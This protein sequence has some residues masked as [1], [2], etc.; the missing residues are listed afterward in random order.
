MDHTGGGGV[1]VVIVGTGV[2]G[3]ELSLNVVHVALCAGNALGDGLHGGV[4]Q[5]FY[6]ALALLHHGLDLSI[7]VTGS[8]I[9]RGI[10]GLLG[11]LALVGLVLIVV[12]LIFGVC[13]AEVVGIILHALQQ[14]VVLVQ[15][16]LVD[17]ELA[18]QVILLHV[19]IRALDVGHEVA[20][21]HIAALRN[22]HLGNGAGITGHDI[23]FIAGLHGACVLADINAVGMG[24]PH[25]QKQHEDAHQ[26]DKSVAIRR[27]LFFHHDAAVLQIRKVL[28]F[29]RHN[30]LVSIKTSTTASSSS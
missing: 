18:F 19:D 28:N 23:G 10:K 5:S 9:G 13:L 21:V 16:G 20:L 6:F 30:Y 4:V 1:D 29:N 12:G 25:H 3:I 22:I 8:L 7:G 14:L 26:N 2:Q 17:L 11:D 24:A 15:L 27:Q